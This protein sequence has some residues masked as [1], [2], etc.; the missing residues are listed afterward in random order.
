MSVPVIQS[1]IDRKLYC[2]AELIYSNISALPKR[3]KDVEVEARGLRLADAKAKGQKP[4]DVEVKS[5]KSDDQRGPEFKSG[6]FIS[7]GSEFKLKN[8]KW[9]NLIVFL[10]A[11]NSST[12]KTYFLI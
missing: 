1:G 11:F 4:T 12:N 8:N 5:Q 9:E 10:I 3:L 2:L 6:S 7:A